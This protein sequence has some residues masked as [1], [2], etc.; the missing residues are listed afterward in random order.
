MNYYFINELKNTEC[1]RYKSGNGTL[2]RSVDLINFGNI[3]FEV[4]TRQQ[5]GHWSRATSLYA[6]GVGEVSSRNHV[7]MESEI[8]LRP[9]LWI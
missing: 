4:H 2:I 3:F 8:V 5:C 1:N 9:M 6:E 7:V